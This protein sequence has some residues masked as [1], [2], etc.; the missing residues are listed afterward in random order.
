MFNADPEH[1]K[2]LTGDML[3]LR[4]IGAEIYV[5]PVDTQTHSE[6]LIVIDKW[7][8]PRGRFRWRNHPEELV[9]LRE[10]LPKLLDETEPPPEPPKKPPPVFD[11]ET[12]L[13]IA[14]PADSANAARQVESQSPQ[15]TPSKLEATADEQ[16]VDEVTPEPL[17][18]PE[19]AASSTRTDS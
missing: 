14:P 6:H 19:T 5:V 17:P 12:G 15:E 8:Q 4:R 16:P 11:E 3:L 9:E 2:F 18:E 1:W 10:L 7:G 13:P